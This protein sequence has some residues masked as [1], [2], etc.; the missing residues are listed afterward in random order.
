[1]A[2]ANPTA[3]GESNEVDLSAKLATREVASMKNT[4]HL[5]QGEPGRGGLGAQAGVHISVI[6][7]DVVDESVDKPQALETRQV[8]RWVSVNMVRNSLQGRRARTI[9]AALFVGRGHSGVATAA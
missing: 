6:D 3:A 9:R 7:A 4:S 5:E 8:I 2:V 1:M